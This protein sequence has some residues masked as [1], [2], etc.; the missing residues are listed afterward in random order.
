M[1]NNLFITRLLLLCGMALSAVVA[2][3]AAANPVENLYVESV[4]VADQQ[5]IARSEAAA[6]GMA[7]VL[8]RVSGS[9]TVLL[10]SDIQRA[11]KNA[12]RYLNKFSYQKTPPSADSSI[13]G[14]QPLP[15]TLE[16]QFRKPAILDLLRASNEPIWAE[17]RPA[18][19]VWLVVDDLAG[20]RLPL[21]DDE[22]ELRQIVEE[23]A[24]RRGLPLVWP[25]YDLQEQATVSL[26]SLWAADPD[27]IAL[28]S[29][30]YDVSGT[31]L[32]RLLGTSDGKW[33]VAWEYNFSDGSTYWDSECEVLAN[34]INGP[35]DA[36]AEL[37]SSRYALISTDQGNVA[38]VKIVGVSSFEDYGTLLFYFKQLIAVS[39]VA[40]S[41]I[42]GDV[43]EFTLGLTAN[44]TKL[45]ELIS[46]NK[47]LVPVP[48]A[49][50]S[51]EA[52]SDNSLVYQ[53]R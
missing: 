13:E 2:I 22:T 49:E 37:M 43:F 21:G 11:I 42:K 16:L 5:A 19:L 40:L 17:D 24:A 12:A 36:V 50:G 10:N 14:L 38:K 23:S 45:E 31:L 28:A 15:Y 53:W 29:Q 44:R 51:D 6:T 25:V 33:R 3:N 30:R 35:I 48:T 18:T 34:C 7:P 39:D 47:R 1:E 4:A 8:I 26:D 46:L 32:G 52:V 20:R 41:S 27:A 9:S